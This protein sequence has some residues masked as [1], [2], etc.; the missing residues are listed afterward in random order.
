M[1]FKSSDCKP[2]VLNFLL[3]GAYM[4]VFGPITFATPSSALT[5]HEKSLESASS[6]S[7]ISSTSPTTLSLVTTKAHAVRRIHDDHRPEVHACPTNPPPTN[8]NPTTVTTESTAT[9]VD[10]LRREIGVTN[11]VTPLPMIS[12]PDHLPDVNDKMFN[13]RSDGFKSAYVSG[14]KLWTEMKRSFATPTPVPWLDWSG[15]S[16]QVN[17]TPSFSESFGAFLQPQYM[18]GA[19]EQENQDAPSEGFRNIESGDYKVYNLSTQ[20]GLPDNVDWRFEYVNWFAPDAR[21]IL[22]ESNFA[23]IQWTEL[24]DTAGARLDLETLKPRPDRYGWYKAPHRWAE[25]IATAWLVACRGDKVPTSALKYVAR[26]AVANEPTIR[27][28]DEMTGTERTDPGVL[29]W[30]PLNPYFYALLGTPNGQ[31][32]VKL[33]SQYVDLFSTK[34]DPHDPSKITR[35]KSIAEVKVSHTTLAE[36]EEMYREAEEEFRKEGITEPPSILPD[37]AFIFE[38]IE[39]PNKY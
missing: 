18:L 13:G 27:L 14:T 24:T 3:R 15:W 17:Q 34:G 11:A 9:T 19:L 32:I 30:T 16:V 22:T 12:D 33:L 37:L 38:D 39:P 8:L 6:Y 28:L 20:E 25:A 31:G 29:N 26:L 10:H 21:I 5:D 23:R 2:S 4:I 36:A 35:V 1:L 7:P